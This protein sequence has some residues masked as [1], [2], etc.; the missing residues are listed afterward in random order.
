M[1]Y[2]DLLT[3]RPSGEIDVEERVECRVCFVCV[4]LSVLLHSYCTKTTLYSRCRILVV[5]SYDS[6]PTPTIRK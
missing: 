3:L 5:Q 4:V 2:L 1:D 6:R